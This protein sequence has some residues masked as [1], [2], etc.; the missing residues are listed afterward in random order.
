M[1][2][3]LTVLV[4]ACAAFAASFAALSAPVGHGGMVMLDRATGLEA[5]RTVSLRSAR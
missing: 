1:K 3:L 5:S 4:G 2:A